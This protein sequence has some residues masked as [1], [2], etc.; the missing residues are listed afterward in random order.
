[1][2]PVKPEWHNEDQVEQAMLRWLGTNSWSTDL[3]KGVIGADIV[4]RD[5]KGATWVMEVK[6]YPS[7][8]MKKDGAL[9]SIN[10]RRSQ[11]RTWFVEALGQIL[12][13]VTE[14][15]KNYALIFPDHPHDSY[16]EERSRALPQFLRKQLG[17]WIFLI[18]ESGSLRAL[19]PDLGDFLR[20]DEVMD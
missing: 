12:T 5:P 20:W 6:G 8:F 18:S 15:G 13:R 1:M 3:R 10:S 11:R 7:T 4:A 2:R 9:K 14:P 19:S 16:F 17:L